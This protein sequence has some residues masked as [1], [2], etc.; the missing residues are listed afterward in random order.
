M[1]LTEGRMETDQLIVPDAFGVVVRME[2]LLIQADLEHSGLEVVRMVPFQ[3]QAGPEV[4]RGSEV[5]G[6][7]ELTRSLR[8][9]VQLVVVHMAQDLRLGPA[10]SEPVGRTEQD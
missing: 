7:K 4:R 1:K 5:A 10:N 6:H 3:A 9:P 2:Q 8:R